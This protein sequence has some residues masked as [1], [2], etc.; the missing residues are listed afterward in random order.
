[1]MNASLIVFGMT[2]TLPRSPYS[3]PIYSPIDIHKLLVE[4]HPDLGLYH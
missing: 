1:M 4:V 2:R 3:L